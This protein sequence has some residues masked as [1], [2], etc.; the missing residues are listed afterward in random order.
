MKL[1]TKT[2]KPK[3][4]IPYSIWYWVLVGALIWLGIILP[5]TVKADTLQIEVVG[6]LSYYNNT[7][8]DSVIRENRLELE[9]VPGDVTGDGLVTSG[10]L[11]SM[12]RHVY[13]GASLPEPQRYESS[14]LLSIQNITVTGSADTTIVDTTW[15]MR[16]EVIPQ[17]VAP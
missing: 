7:V 16:H 5:F 17:E 12:I 1:K 3:P 8:A 4:G 10:D 13:F 9:C 11:W 6:E 2:S 15:V 14:T